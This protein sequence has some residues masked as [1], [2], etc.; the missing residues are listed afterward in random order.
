MM[1]LTLVFNKDFSKVL[2]CYHEKQHAYNFIGGYSTQGESEMDA[3]Y[4]ELIEETGISKGA[5]ELMFVRYE[6]VTCK[7]SYYKS[8]S[9][10]MMVTAGILK[11]DIELKPEVNRLEWVDIWDIDKLI[12]RSFG[13]GNCYTYLR[14]A[15]DILGR[16]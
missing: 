4:R 5:I 9:W 8:P 15:L 10:S 16:S 13:H 11:S 7:S 3:S 1:T 14:E 6:H 2:M 12:Y